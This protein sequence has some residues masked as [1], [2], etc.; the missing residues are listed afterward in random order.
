MGRDRPL[1]G[2]VAA[3]GALTALGALAALTACTADAGTARGGPSTTAPATASPSPDPPEAIC[4][5]LVTYWAEDQLAPDGGSGA[6][7]QQMGLSDGQNTILMNAV[8]TAKAQVERAGGD[9]AARAG[10]LAGAQREIREQCARRYAD[11]GGRSAPPGG[12]P[13]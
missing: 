4:A 10:A 1:S 2:L 13:R 7:Y 11:R 5:E 8:R 12:W 3:V 6:D 9:T